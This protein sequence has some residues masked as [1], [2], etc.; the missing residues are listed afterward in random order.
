MSFSVVEKCNTA[1]RTIE[2]MES[3]KCVDKVH[4]IRKK[5]DIFVRFFKIFFAVLFL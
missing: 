2:N 3:I 4:V 5:G 1:A